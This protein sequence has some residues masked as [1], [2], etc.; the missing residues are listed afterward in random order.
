MTMS[1]VHVIE[2]RGS[3]TALGETIGRALQAILPKA[4]ARHRQE[5]ARYGRDQALALARPLR[6][7]LKGHLS[8]RAE[9]LPALTHAAAVDVD[10][11]VSL[12]AL[13]K[14]LFLARR[15]RLGEECTSLAVPRAAATDNCV[16]LAHNEDAL[17]YRHEEPCVV[18]ARPADE[19]IFVAIAY[20]GLFVYQG[21]NE[22]GIGS[23][24]NA[25]QMTDIWIGVPKL[26]LSREVLRASTLTRVIQATDLAERANGNNHLIATADR[27][28]YDIEVSG[29]HAALHYVGNQ[30]FAH[31][32]HVLAPELRSLEE[33]N[34]RDSQLRRHRTQHLLELTAGQRTVE[35]LQALLR[36]HANQP[37]A[38][39]KH[40]DP[41][42]DQAS[43]TIAGL[44]VDV[45]G[46]ELGIAPGV[47]CR[48]AF[49]RITLA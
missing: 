45:T 37:N 25:L 8:R 4:I 47:P 34:T 28:I 9:E 49:E 18:R 17:L 2:A 43:R 1:A 29:R 20:G 42:A 31:T 38:L 30:P 48:V 11:M 40:L 16:L 23:T 22:I 41:A 5:R 15:I 12:N 36:D 24:S 19:P 32:N 26:F 3:A 27:E 10:A 35:T 6:D 21:V 44:V 39:C 46:R 7:D 14:T 33:S 13:Q